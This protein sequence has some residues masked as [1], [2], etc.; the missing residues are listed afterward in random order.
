MV[1]KKYFFLL[2]ACFLLSGHFFANSEYVQSARAESYSFFVEPEYDLL[3]RSQITA[4]LKGTSQRA[5][6]FID[7]EWWKKLS[8]GEQLH[9]Q[10]NISNLLVEFDNVIYPELTKFLGNIWSPGIDDDSKITILALPLIEAAGGYIN[11]SDEYPRIEI[12]RSNEREMV[13]LNVVHLGTHLA[14][15][16]LAHEFQ[17]SITFYQK[18]V[19]HNV[20]EDV[21]LNEA[22]SEYV[23]T[24]LGYDNIFLGSNLERRV[25]VFLKNYSDPLGEFKNE[26]PDY[27]TLNLFLQYLAD[28]YGKEIVTELIKDEKVGIESTNNALKKRGFNANFSEVFTNWAIANLLNNCAI[29][30][31]FCYKNPNLNSNNLRLAPNESLAL[32]GKAEKVAIKDWQPIYYKFEKIPGKNKTLKISLE[33]GSVKDA[34]KIP[35]LIYNSDGEILVKF[36]EIM[37]NKATVSIPDFGGKVDSVIVIVL[38]KSKFSDFSSADPSTTFS[39]SADFS[40][41]AVSSPAPIPAPI[42][43]LISD[44]A[45]LRAKDDYKIYLIERGKRHWISSPQVFELYNLNWDDV[46]EV[47]FQDLESFPRAKLLKARED[48]KVYYLTESGTIRH[49]PSAEAFLSYGNKWE[50]IIEIDPEELKA[51]SPNNLIQ[52]VGD[53]KIYKL[54]SGKKRWIKTAAAF[55]RL[56]L[57]WSKIAPVNQIEFDAYPAGVPIN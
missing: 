15:G 37:D 31:F 28:H 29:G 35:Y 51:Y 9:L 5:Y 8:G 19:L 45:T 20:A 16:F 54:E 56:K 41:E 33:T 13:Y 53:Y 4:E 14:K 18:D 43:E 57:D 10:E 50:D 34:F 44:G 3:K 40:E 6:F 30:E 12:P 39:I 48:Y 7:D 1:K 55:N 11:Y 17:H 21:W 47:D 25:G 32:P 36:M 22:R 49:I 52:R 24:Y 23:S 2:G 38:K 46:K 42:P 26:P 27:A